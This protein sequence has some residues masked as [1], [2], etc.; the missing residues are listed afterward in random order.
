MTW[1]RQYIREVLLTESID[2][3]INGQISKLVSIDGLIDIKI[4]GGIEVSARRYDNT[5]H[6]LGEVFA[7]HSGGKTGPC[8]N[9]LIIGGSG[10]GDLVRAKE[11][12]G[13]LMYDICMEA[14]TFLGKDGLGPDYT[15]VSDDAAAVWDYYL[16]NRPDIIVKQ[17]DITQSPRTPELTDDCTQDDGFRAAAKRFPGGAKAAYGTDPEYAE[18]DKSKDHPR[19]PSGNL[20]KEFV[21]YWFDPSNSLTKTYHKVGTPVIEKL[22]SDLRL[23]PRAAKSVQMPYSQEEMQKVWDN[24]WGQAYPGDHQRIP[25]ISGIWKNLAGF[26]Q[27][28]LKKKHPNAPWERFS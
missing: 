13:P 10:W 27:T 16:N 2:A 12:L 19:N 17:R 6:E 5:N 20:S 24:S 22:R 23:T 7:L 28:L 26:D 3:K 1:L 18:W 14:T 8:N 9:A 4:T 15:S 21:E 25:W 11:G